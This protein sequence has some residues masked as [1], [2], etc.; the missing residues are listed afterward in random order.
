MCYGASK[1]YPESAIAYDRDGEIT[2]RICANAGTHSTENGDERLSGTP[3]DTLLLCARETA[4]R[5]VSER[6]AIHLQRESCRQARV[7]TCAQAMR[8]LAYH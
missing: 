5:R 6:R 2:P 7:E 8:I 3:C 1:D 4:K